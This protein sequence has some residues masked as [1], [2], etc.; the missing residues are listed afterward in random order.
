[1]GNKKNELDGTFSKKFIKCIITAVTVGLTV[2]LVTA[3]LISVIMVKR[4]FPKSSVCIF[5]TVAYAL[6]CL[7]AGFTAA[8]MTGKK[9]A[10]M[11]AAA[12]IAFFILYAVVG[13]LVNG[14]ALS[15]TIAVRL[16]IAVSVA[17]IGGV[18]GVNIKHKEKY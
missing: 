8:K 11:G 14:F 15:V 7:A 6:G 10:A 9:G 12:G 5:S 4:D 3:L 1:M 13:L 16:A 2:L 18:F 17:A